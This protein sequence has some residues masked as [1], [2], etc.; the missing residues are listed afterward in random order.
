M[1]TTHTLKVKNKATGKEHDM[2]VDINGD[3][4]DA[5]KHVEGLPP[6]KGA[7]KGFE[8]VDKAEVA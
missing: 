6:S 5:K 7:P 4:E 1:R 2:T 8:V 3:I